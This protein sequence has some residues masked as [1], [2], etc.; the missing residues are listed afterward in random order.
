MYTIKYI[1]SPS[2]ELAIIAAVFGIIALSILLLGKLLPRLRNMFKR[3][4]DYVDEP[5]LDDKISESAEISMG[6]DELYEKACEFVESQGEISISLLQYQ[7][8]IG[9]NRALQLMG[10][11]ERDGLIGPPV[12]T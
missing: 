7:F 1:V 8:K 11:M 12:N 6:Y 2:S 3:E 5:E 9:Y 4:K 10:S